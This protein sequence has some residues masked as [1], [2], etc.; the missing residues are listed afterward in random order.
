MSG[1]E[2]LSIVTRVLATVGSLTQQEPRHNSVPRPERWELRPDVWV[3]SQFHSAPEVGVFNNFVYAHEP[4]QSLIQV[5]DQNGEF[6]R[7]MGSNEEQPDTSAQLVAFGFSS[8]TLW[9]FDYRR[10]RVSL[11]SAN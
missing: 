7:D 2:M 9:T 3:Q 1:E 8:D 11:F 5:F 6:V 10:R 4:T